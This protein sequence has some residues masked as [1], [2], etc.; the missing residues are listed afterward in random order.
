MLAH[1]IFTER[2]ADLELHAAEPHK[3]PLQEP[4][5]VADLHGSHD[6]ISGHAAPGELH[7]RGT[8]CDLQ[9]GGHDL[10]EN[11]EDL[12]QDLQH[13]ETCSCQNYLS[14]IFNTYV[15]KSSGQI[16]SK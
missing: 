6:E 2:S 9:T 16:S 12:P 8:S 7:G 13:C 10:L 14:L 15:P 3:S 4:E 11:G 5:L 1:D